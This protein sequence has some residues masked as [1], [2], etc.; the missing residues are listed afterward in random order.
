MVWLCILKGVTSPAKQLQY[1][2]AATG[3][4]GADCSKMFRMPGCW[5]RG[6]GVTAQTCVSCKELS[7]SQLM[8]VHHCGYM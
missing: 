6:A 3:M 2:A 1:A 7:A 5:P 8:Y 4:W